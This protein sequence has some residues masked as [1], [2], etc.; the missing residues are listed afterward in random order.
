MR[1]RR[2][3]AKWG[4]LTLLLLGGLAVGSGIVTSPSPSTGS[5]RGG[6]H[7]LVAKGSN[8]NTITGTDN[9][10]V[11]SNSNG[12][13]RKTFGVRV[14]DIGPIYPGQT[15]HLPVVWSNPNSFDIQVVSYSLSV[16]VPTGSSSTCPASSLQ[17]ADGKVSLN[18]AV[19][20]VRNGSS[21][22]SVPVTLPVSAPEGCQQ[23]PFSITVDATAVMK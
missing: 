1:D 18:P 11:P 10:V 16:N 14:G 6:S 7:A 21:S 2:C 23:V 5:A 4:L 19:A 12:N 13:C 17:V 3:T 15:R 8:G 9:C 20:V 22:S